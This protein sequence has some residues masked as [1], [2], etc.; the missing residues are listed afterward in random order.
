M[1][2]IITNIHLLML[3]KLA[4]FIGG[5]IFSTAFLLPRSIRNFGIWKEEKNNKKLT[6]AI[7]QFVAA[8]F[9]LTFLLVGIL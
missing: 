9:F 4:I 8:I 7:E 6:L 2:H 3:I 1:H 5:F